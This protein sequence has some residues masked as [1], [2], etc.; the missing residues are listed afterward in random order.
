M[1]DLYFFIF[2]FSI[3]QLVDNILPMSGFEPGISGVVGD[4]STN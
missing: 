1:H 4:R 3:G 2:D